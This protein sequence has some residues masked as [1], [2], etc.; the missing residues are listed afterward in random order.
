MWTP[1]IECEKQ[2]PF[3]NDNKQRL[4]TPLIAMEPRMNGAPGYWVGTVAS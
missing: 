4:G 1:A 2:I 3:G